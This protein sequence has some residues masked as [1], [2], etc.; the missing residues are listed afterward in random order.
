LVDQSESRLR[1]WSSRKRLIWEAR[2]LTRG[3]EAQQVAKT[4]IL[5]PQL[6]NPLEE[7]ICRRVLSPVPGHGSGVCLLGESKFWLWSMPRRG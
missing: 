3:G 1:N 7:V 6:V 5:F 2:P 4:Q